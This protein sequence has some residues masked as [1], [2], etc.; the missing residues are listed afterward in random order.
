MIRMSPDRRVIAAGLASLSL[1][2]AVL[3][4]VL[5][6]LTLAI[7]LSETEAGLVLSLSALV[8]LFAA[9]FWGA[10]VDRIGAR[11]VFLMGVAGGAVSFF[12]VGL[13]LY[14][15]QMRVLAPQGT[16]ALLLCARMIYGA[17]ACA[18]LPAAVSHLAA[19]SSSETRTNALALP[20]SAFTLGSLGGAALVLPVTYL[21]GPIAPL[22]LAGGLGV[23]VLLTRGALP[24]SPP[25][26]A[27]LPEEPAKRFDPELLPLLAATLCGLG[28][29]S[30]VYSMLPLLLQTRGELSTEA[31]V[32]AA[33]LS[34]ALCTTASLLGIRLAARARLGPST[35]T[36]S[37]ALLAAVGTLAAF[38]S[39]TLVLTC[40]AMAL[41]SLGLGLI[42]P[43]LQAMVSLRAKQQGRSAGQLSAATG[44]AWVIGPALGL[45]G[46]QALEADILPLLTIGFLP[47]VAL[48]LAQRKGQATKACSPK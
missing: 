31:A 37:G 10:R 16:F 30:A 42:T 36:R 25:A 39:A 6:P 32:Q 11:P 9:P 12:G 24:A 40:A 45:A 26:T 29:A 41:L 1:G 20:G 21:A 8:V 5:V 28:A 46:Y 47:L 23:A 34:G 2:N 4:P 15:G 27:A 35:L 19:T 48:P 3:L 13:A 38:W 44:A 17:C 7:G 18:A 22:F 14:L 33:A 43:S